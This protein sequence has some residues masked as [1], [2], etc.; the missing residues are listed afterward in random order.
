MIALVMI[1]PF[2]LFL[3]LVRFFLFLVVQI[4]V[5]VFRLTPS[6]NTLLSV[7]LFDRVVPLFILVLPLGTGEGGRAKQKN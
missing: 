5:S 3:L 7:P 2:S 6:L 1:A 4:F